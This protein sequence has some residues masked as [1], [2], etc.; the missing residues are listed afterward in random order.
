MSASTIEVKPIALEVKRERSAFIKFPWQIYRNDPNWV[1]PLIMDMETRL[2]RKHPFFEYGDMQ[3]FMAYR[4]TEAVGRIAAVT[5]S[6]HFKEHGENAGFFGF[7]ECIDDQAV[8]NALFDTAKAW[9]KEK[10]VA[11]IIGPASPSI[12]YDYGLLVEGFDDPP[13]L[14]MT[15]NPEYYIKLIEGYGFARIKQLYAWKI[16]R[17]NMMANEKLTRVAIAAKA[18]SGVEIRKINKKKMKEELQ[19]FKMLYNKGWEKNWG[20][21]PFTDREM[22]AMASELAPL[23]NPD[24]ALFAYIDGKPV[25]VALAIQDYNA[26]IKDFDGKLFP[27]NVLKL[28]VFPNKKKLTWIRVLVLGLLPEYR[29]RGLDAVL[30]YELMQAGEKLEHFKHGEGSWVLEDNTA[31]NRAMEVANGKI[32]K[33]YNMYEIAM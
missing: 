15:Y 28:L 11:K 9:L 27:F 26:I 22:D 31:L 20:S 30:Y 13:R 4:G 23:V 8:A 14:L 18:R 21:I 33:R 25:G 10:G 3:L 32:Y 16:D 1:P 19:V 12:N 24:L 6:L 17:S 29:G 7:F 5:N 2:N